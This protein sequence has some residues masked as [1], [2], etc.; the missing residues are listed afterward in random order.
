VWLARRVPQA[1]LRWCVVVVGA[2]LTVYY[3]VTG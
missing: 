1:V 2:A 3:F